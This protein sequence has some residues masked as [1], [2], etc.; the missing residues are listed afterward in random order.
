MTVTTSDEL[1]AAL[2]IAVKENAS[3]QRDNDELR[4]RHGDPIAIVGMACR[5]PGGVDTPEALWAA[6]ASGGDLISEFPA[7]RGWHPGLYDAEPGK[8][9]RTYTRHGGFLSDVADFDASFFGIGPREARIMD[10]QQRQLLEVSWEALE[11]AGLDPKSL[12]DTETGVFTGSFCWDYLPRMSDAPADI[13]DHLLTANGGSVLPGRVAYA[14]GLTGPAVSVDTACSSSL[15]ALHLAAQ[16][17]RAGECSLALASGVTVMSTPGMLLG[18]SRQQGLAPDGRCKSFAAGADGVGLSEGVGVLVLERLSDARRHGREILAVVRGSAVNQDGASNGLTAPNGPAQQRVMRAAL[19]AAG[20]C[21]SEVD[22]VEAHGTGTKLGDP[23]EAQ[24]IL[25]T[26]GRDRPAEQP[27]WLGSIKSNMGH[28]QA[29]AG[30]AGIMKMVLAMRHGTLPPT[31]H[32]GRPSPYVDW[33]SGNA[34]LLTEARPWPELN[35]PRRAAVSSFGLSGTNAHVILEHATETV[36]PQLESS[37]PEAG[38]MPWV[39]TGRTARALSDQAGRLLDYIGANPRASALDIGAALTARTAFE[40][41]AIILGSRLT[42]LAA[43]AASAAR[44]EPRANVIVGQVHTGSTAFVFAGQGSQRLG[45]GR[46]LHRCQP[47]F[48]RA[49]D[50]A[51]AELDRYTNS[52][53]TDI[54]WGTDPKLLEHTGFVQAGL[55]AMEVALCRMLETYGLTPDCVIGHSVGEIAAAHIAGVLSLSDAASLVAARGRL[56]QALPANGAMVAIQAAE[57]EVV[58]HLVAGVAIAAVNGPRAVVISGEVDAVDTVAAIFAALGRK[59]TRLRVSHAFHSVLMEPMLEEFAAAIAGIDV[60]APRIPIV[61]NLT[62]EFGGSGYGTVDYWI[63]HVREAV[64]FDA[65]IRVLAEA[66]VSRYVEVGPDGGLSAALADSIDLDAVVVPVLRPGSPEMETTL[67]AIARIFVNGGDIRWAAFFAETGARPIT[68]PTYAFQRRRYWWSAPVAVHAPGHRSIDHPFLSA[69]VDNPGTGAMTLSGRLAPETQSWLSDHVILGTALL[70]ATAFVEMA[71]RAGDEVGCATL[72]ELT[73]QAPLSISGAGRELLVVVEAEIDAGRSVAIYSSGSDDRQEWLLHARGVLGYSDSEAV[74][75]ELLDWPPL[76][77]RSVNVTDLYQALAA[78]GYHYGDSYRGVTAAWRRGTDLFAEISISAFTPDELAR[79]GLHPALMDA[80]MHVGLLETTETIVPFAWTDVVLHAAGASR[81]RVKLSGTS[82]RL[83]LRI[84][85]IHGRPVLTAQSVDGRHMVS[86]PVD[87]TVSQHESIL[88]VEWRPHTLSR[89]AHL[90]VVE[91]HEH[92]GTVPAADVVLVRCLPGETLDPPVAAAARTATMVRMLQHWLAAPELAESRL[93]VLTRGAVALA[94]EEILD[95]AGAALWGLVRAARSENPGRI[96]LADV[97]EDALDP[98]ALAASDEPEIVVRNGSAWTPALLQAALPVSR[99]PDLTEGTVLITGGT[100]GLGATIARHLVNEHGVRAL[101]LISRSGLSSAAA[102]QL[103]AELTAAGASVQISSCDVADRDAVRRLLAEIPSAAPLSG[104]V[105]TAGVLDDAVIMSMSP[106][107]I[108]KVFAPKVFGAWHL[109]ELTQDLELRMFV[110]F[111]SVS[112]V[113]GGPGQGNY[114]AANAFLDALAQYRQNRGLAATSIAWGPWASGAGMVGRLDAINRRRLARTGLVEM[115][116]AQAVSSFDAIARS[117]VAVAVAAQL[118]ASVLQHGGDTVP[119]MLHRPGRGVTRLSAESAD[120][121]SAV[122]LTGLTAEARSRAVLDLVLREA[123][124]TLGYTETD[125]ID[126]HRPFLEVGFDS[127]SAVQFRN[128]LRTATGLS[129][130]ATVVFDHPTP[131]TLAESVTRMLE[132]TAP[133]PDEDAR[134]R[135]AIAAIPLSTLREADLLDRLLEL[136][137]LDLPVDRQRRS[138][139]HIKDLS[140][141]ELIRMALGNI[142]A[143][144]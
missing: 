76:D 117:N 69:V 39:L 141:E 75:P 133:E 143:E 103:S 19:A 64:R 21:A 71:I 56:M 48:A 123:A 112:G 116:A 74:E 67:E 55:F 17:L 27:V 16:S 85:D 114:A 50:A 43:G 124:A 94:G 36:A 105:H 7:D 136:A 37:P 33:S 35:R 20:L 89:R 134:L 93:L 10:P 58:S 62:G 53:L 29:A 54:V 73:V 96:I 13:A 144:Q 131:V 99:G 111:S 22:A 98:A 110:L 106:E 51:A 77:A 38:R 1:L 126:P 137:G 138:A 142:G 52:T 122:S 119:R 139:A 60:A 108:D 65:G 82:S 84:A 81:L 102:Q 12:R 140:E 42:D 88:G 97:D 31:L 80:A 49:W 15:V 47:A 45:M 4:G 30:V 8:T 130:S 24:S 34:A 14:L 11:R 125:E 91:W 78:R 79:F 18:F 41:R 107:R 135:A 72:K 66:G 83:T 9:G 90:S 100:G 109:H 70:P 59:T 3:L 68:L 87:S 46:E 23:I 120:G 132:E 6:L 95:L 104:V 115:P 63:R 129:L 113:L 118:D 57:T 25:A 86:D 101:L 61:S 32:I 2:R 40:H 28:T 127:L 92:A 5:F 44:S 121:A 128:R 26:Y